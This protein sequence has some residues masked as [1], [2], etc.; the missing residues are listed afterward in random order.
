[1]KRSFDETMEEDNEEKEEESRKKIY[2]NNFSNNFPNNFSTPNNSSNNSSN[3]SSKKKLIDKCLEQILSAN[4]IKFITDQLEYQIMEN[5]K[6]H[7][8][9]FFSGLL[10]VNI[11]PNLY[12]KNKETIHLLISNYLIEEGFINFKCYIYKHEEGCLGITVTNNIYNGYY[13]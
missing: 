6:K 7:K 5:V 13:Y 9:L 4:T 2:L 1:M 10:L 12:A 11:D 8:N 3:H